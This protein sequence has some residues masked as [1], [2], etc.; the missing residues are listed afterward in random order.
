MRPLRPKP[1]SRCPKQR[2]K[3]ECSPCSVAMVLGWVLHIFTGPLNTVVKSCSWNVLLSLRTMVLDPV[4]LTIHHE[5]A[6]FRKKTRGSRWLRVLLNRLNKHGYSHTPDR[7]GH[8]HS[9]REETPV[10]QV[11]SELRDRTP[12][13][14]MTITGTERIIDGWDTESLW[15]NPHQTAQGQ[16]ARHWSPKRSRWL[17]TEETDVERLG[18]IVCSTRRSPGKGMA[19]KLQPGQA[20]HGVFLQASCGIRLHQRMQPSLHT[21]TV[22]LELGYVRL[23]KTVFPTML[24]PTRRFT[25]CRRKRHCLARSRPYSTRKT[26]ENSNVVRI[27][28][29][30]PV[31]TKGRRF[32]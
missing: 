29:A 9:G 11:T 14:D 24:V 20:S 6:I 2:P 13:S 5:Q 1:T 19:E 32:P 12:V 23:G 25:C 15:R 16:A 3:G 7:W 17:E 10:R 27:P 26:N 31:V 22:Q 30:T 21:P 28:K 18:T 8:L 4:H